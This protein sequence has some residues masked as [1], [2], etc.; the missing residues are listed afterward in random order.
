MGIT[1]F[2]NVS[3]SNKFTSSLDSITVVSSPALLLSPQAIVW[4]W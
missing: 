4:F 3:V 1:R 2:L